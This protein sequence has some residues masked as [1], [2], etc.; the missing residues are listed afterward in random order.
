[1]RNGAAYQFFFLF[2]PYFL[3]FGIAHQRYDTENSEDEQEQEH[4]CRTQLRNDEAD[5]ETGDSRGRRADTTGGTVVDGIACAVAGYAQCVQQRHHHI[6]APHTDHVE[7]GSQ[8][9]RQ[10]VYK[11]REKQ[12]QH[13]LE[14]EISIFVSRKR[15]ARSA[16]DARSGCGSGRKANLPLPA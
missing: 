11:R 3:N 4:P 8:H 2:I 10:A 5:Y 14:N 9:Q 13:R 7:N 15:S 1:M 16:R 12:M 6:T